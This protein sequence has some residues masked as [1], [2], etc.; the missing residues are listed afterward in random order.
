MIQQYGGSCMSERKMYQW[1]K[2]FKKAKHLLLMNIAEVAVSDA[3]IAHMDTL[4]SEK[5]QISVVIVATMLNFSIGSAH[6]I[7]HQTLK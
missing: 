3:N 5:N 7:I 2:D 6:G 4:I 1:Q